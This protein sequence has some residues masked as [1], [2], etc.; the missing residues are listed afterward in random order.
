MIP[1]WKLKRE[2]KRPVDQLRSAVLYPFDLFTKHRH[3]K[4]FH[5]RI[6][7]IEGAQ[8]ATTKFAALLIYQPKGLVGTTLKTCQHL[9]ASGY[10]VLVVSNTPLAPDA[11]A[12]LQPLVWRTLERPNVGY[13]FGGYRDSVRFLRESGVDLQA[14]VM[15]NDSIWW[16][17]CEGDTALPQLEQLGTDFGGMILRPASRRKKA[18]NRSPHLQSYFFWFG[19]KLLGSATFVDFWKTYRL[20]GF[21]YNAIRHGELQLTRVLLEAGFSAA[22]LFSFEAL[23]AKLADQSNDYLCTVLRFGAYRYP[24]MAKTAQRLRDSAVQDAAWRSRVFD[25]FAEMDR[26]S[27]FQLALRFAC[28][29]LLGLNI[30]K[31]SATEPKNS[32]HHVGRGNY[33][34]AIAEGLLPAPMPEVL[35]EIEERHSRGAAVVGR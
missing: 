17:L 24:E 32:L 1:L 15:M 30:L 12:A 18:S 21:K 26:T 2:L 6:T 35:A 19:P 25:L 3:D 14:L 5:D 10:S 33:L 7:V 16:P 23:M 13:D 28:V 20:S 4:A 22:P 34:E 31:R 11:R 9:A 27:E 8:T 29:D